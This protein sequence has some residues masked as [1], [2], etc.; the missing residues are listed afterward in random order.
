MNNIFEFHKEL[1][2]KKVISVFILAVFIIILIVVF[3]PQN[4]EK[5]LKEEEISNPYKTYISADNKVSLELPKRY[6]LQEIKSNYLLQ[7]QAS[8]GLLINIEEKSI[9]FG[10]SLNEVVN[11]DKNVYTQKF[12]NAF[13]VSDLEE[14]NLENSN[15]LSSYTYNFKYISNSN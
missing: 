13:D 7:L 1:N 4:T 10:K 2:I 5:K 11:S 15:T 14:F 6:N 3:H 8:D 9:L 12:E